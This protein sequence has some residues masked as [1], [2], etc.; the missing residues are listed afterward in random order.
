MVW[1]IIT[2][3]KIMGITCNPDIYH[4]YALTGSEIDNL[5]IINPSK[6]QALL[7]SWYSKKNCTKI[8]VAFAGP[9]L[10][11]QFN[12]STMPAGFMTNT[13]VLSEQKTYTAGIPF[14]VFIQYHCILQALGI[15]LQTITTVTLVLHAAQQTMLTKEALIVGCKK[16]NESF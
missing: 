5:R 6:L 1:L 9:A 12:S 13:C 4:E 2:D 16:L 8:A 10:Y 3:Q 14:G 11:E 7:K 15:T